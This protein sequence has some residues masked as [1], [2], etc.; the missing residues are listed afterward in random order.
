M[1]SALPLGCAGNSE[2]LVDP[3]KYQFHTCAQLAR[4][5]NALR[6]HARELRQLQQRAE[7]E[8]TGAAVARI[9]YE[10]DYLSTVGNMGVI[11]AAARDR[12]CDP[13]ITAAGMLGR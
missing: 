13:P 7:R 5:I 9:A 6:E 3:A 8:P 12:N 10:P 1:I 4:E 2:M 11:E